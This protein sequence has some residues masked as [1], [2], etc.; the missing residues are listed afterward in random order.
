M[1]ATDLS[2]GRGH[3]LEDGTDAIIAFALGGPGSAT[4]AYRDRNGDLPW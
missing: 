2:G 3:S 4:G 1:T